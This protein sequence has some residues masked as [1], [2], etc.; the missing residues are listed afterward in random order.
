MILGISKGIAIIKFN[1]I[2]YSKSF[3]E[4]HSTLEIDGSPAWIDFGFEHSSDDWTCKYCQNINFHGRDVCFKCS[5]VKF[6]TFN[7]RSNVGN[8]DIS[9]IP[10]RF[11]LIKN[12]DIDM[13]PQKVNL[14]FNN[15]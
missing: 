6:S 14:L 1:S 13:T 4:A 7:E 5:K 9:N 15:L 8:D 12:V 3:F 2:E 10:T 11:L